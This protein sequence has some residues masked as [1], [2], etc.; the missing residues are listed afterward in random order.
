M[1]AALAFA[2][3]DF[4]I[5]QHG[6]ENRTPVHRSFLLIRQSMIVNET[7]NRVLALRLHICRN[8]EFADRTAFFHFRVIPRIIKNEEDLLRP[9]KI[10][11]VGRGKLTVPIVGEAEHFQLTPKVRDIFFRGNSRVNAR[12]FG[13]LLRRKSKSV[14]AH[15]VHHA[16]AV[17]SVETRD[18]IRRGISLRMP[19]MKSV[20]TWIW[21][22]VQHVHFLF[23]R[24][25]RRGKSA[26][27]FPVFLPFRFN[28]RRIVSRHNLS[29]PTF[30]YE[31]TKQ[32]ENPLAPNHFET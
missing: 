4:L 18:D 28:N 11:H 15:G 19:D 29:T 24:K 14:P 30:K 9:V 16:N 23:A 20:G 32:R 12:F 13:V 22:H 17:H 2:V 31:S 10:V 21:E 1:T 26:V 7:A 25:T 6:T 27:F 5:R 3:N 8:R